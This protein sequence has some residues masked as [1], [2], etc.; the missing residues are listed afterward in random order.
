MSRHLSMHVTPPQRSQQ[1]TQAW[2]HNPHIW[3]IQACYTT[4]MTH[5]QH[6]TNGDT[7]CSQSCICAARKPSKSYFKH[8]TCS[9]GQGSS[10][11]SMQCHLEAVLKAVA[12][13]FKLAQDGCLGSFCSDQ[14]ALH[15]LML[16]LQHL[17]TT[18]SL[19]TLCVSLNMLLLCC[20]LLHTLPDLSNQ[21]L[22]QSKQASTLCCRC[23]YHR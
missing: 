3:Y 10:G 6:N 5:Q 18:H 13:P 15:L 7:H 2:A 22:F 1:P 12:L 19:L 21:H 9:F 20:K 4:N 16:N 8:K 17:L 11:G 23:S 14:A